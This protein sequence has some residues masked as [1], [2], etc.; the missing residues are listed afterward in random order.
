MDLIEERFLGRL[1]PPEEIEW[2]PE[3]I[4]CIINIISSSSVGG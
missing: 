2:E 3:G 4:S 1:S